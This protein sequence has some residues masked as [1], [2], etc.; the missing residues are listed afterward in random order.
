[1]RTL[2]LLLSLLLCAVGEAQ[3]SAAV[4]RKLYIAAVEI[5]WDYIHQGDVNQAS[6]Q[7]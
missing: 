2:V 4:V 5:G 1:M 7:R 3:Q 6:D